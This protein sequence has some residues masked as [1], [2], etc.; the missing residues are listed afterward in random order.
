MARCPF[1]NWRPIPEN[2]TQPAITATQYIL[3]SAVDHPGPTD[4]GAW[5][6]REDV[7]VESHFYIHLDGTID[8][9]ID[10]SRSADANSGAN[11]RPDG[12]GAVSVETEDEGNPDERPWTSQQLAS[13]IRLGRWLRSEHAIPSRMCRTPDDP[14]IGFHSMWGAPSGWTSVPGKTCPGRARIRQFPDVVAGIAGN[15]FHDDE[16]YTMREGD[17]GA[18]VLA[19]QH[20][21]KT[22]AGIDVTVDGNFG[23]QTAKATREW[24]KRAGLDETGVVSLMTLGLLVSTRA[25]N[26]LQDHRD[27]D[28]H[29][30]VGDHTHTAR[31]RLT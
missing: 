8:Q 1:A 28:P 5:F 24:Q 14:G 6:S 11:R 9:F 19:W 4:L 25:G 27:D 12:T 22:W 7:R 10:T 20:R 26:A 23:Q 13:L 17:K 2:A 21:L 29:G 30:E 3:H 31:V 16:E 18:D 15:T